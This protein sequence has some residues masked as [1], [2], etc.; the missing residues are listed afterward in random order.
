MGKPER[1]PL[2]KPRRRQ[3]DNIKINLLKVGWNHG[4]DFSG[5]G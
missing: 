5:S 2:R 1:R 4:V 3:E